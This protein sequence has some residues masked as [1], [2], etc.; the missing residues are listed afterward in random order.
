LLPDQL[1]PDS[2]TLPLSANFSVNV[3][4]TLAPGVPVESIGNSYATD[5]A[6]P[7]EDDCRE[8]SREI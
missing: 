6:A 7:S 8:I 1:Q 2:E 3:I 4:L 5:T